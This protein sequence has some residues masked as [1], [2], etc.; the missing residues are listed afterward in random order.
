MQD[1]YALLSAHCRFRQ[2]RGLGKLNDLSAEPW[3][4]FISC[5]EVAAVWLSDLLNG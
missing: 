2:I 4:N 1:L 3:R 5:F